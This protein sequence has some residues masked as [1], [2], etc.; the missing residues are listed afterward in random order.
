MSE[1]PLTDDEVRTQV[2]AIVAD[3]FFKAESEEMMASIRIV[4]A[5]CFAG[6]NADRIA[7]IL[8]LN[9]DKVVRPRARRLRE[10]GVW[11]GDRVGVDSFALD[12]EE[13]GP[14]MIELVL[15]ALVAEG[16]VARKPQPDLG[17]TT[18]ETTGSSE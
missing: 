15:M 5:S 11:V 10:G 3:P 8:G 9:R 12:A 17:E 18:T 14:M 13:D 1:V 16:L 4:V 6:T 7:K 2:E